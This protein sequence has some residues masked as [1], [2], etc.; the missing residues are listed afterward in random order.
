MK[1]ILVL[2]ACIVPLMVAP[3]T[4][5]QTTAPSTAPTPPAGTQAPGSGEAPASTM[6]STPAPPAG[7]SGMSNSGASNT[8]ANNS[9]AAMG[10]TQTQA[11]TGLSVK[12]SLMGQAVYNEKD[13]KVGDVADVV[14]DTDGKATTYVIGAGGF[15]GMGEHNVAVPFDDVSLANDKL[16]LQGYTKDRLKAL[17]EVEVAQ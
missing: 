3:I 16:I 2:S 10:A 9:G 14:L 7:N 4:Y 8:G 13:E 11:V 17:P 1:K 15:L 12:M 6:P 5:G